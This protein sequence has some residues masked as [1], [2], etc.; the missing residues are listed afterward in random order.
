MT[1]YETL[2]GGEVLEQVIDRFIDL[3]F[4]DFIIGFWF[5]GKDRVRIK[6]HEVEH[7]ALVLGGPSR[8][9][10]RPLVTAHKP[11]GINQGHFRRRLAI[12]R[13]VLTDAEVDP[14]VIERW[15]AADRKLQDQITDGSDCAPG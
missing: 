2:G 5:K 12:L 4:D 15:I 3:V 1:D 13:K 7:A 8:Y 14:D 9:T 11:L 10:G 6:K